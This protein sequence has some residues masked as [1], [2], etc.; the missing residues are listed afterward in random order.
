MQSLDVPYLPIQIITDIFKISKQ[1]HWAEKPWQFIPRHWGKSAIFK[2]TVEKEH[3]THTNERKQMLKSAKEAKQYS[4]LLADDFWSKLV[5]LQE[6]LL[7]LYPSF[8]PKCICGLPYLLVIPLNS[9]KNLV[10]C[11]DWHARVDFRTLSVLWLEESKFGCYWPS[12][13][14]HQC[15]HQIF[16]C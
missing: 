4:E 7:Y 15:K 9:H 5:I 1:R 10:M 13:K 6:R 8:L 14:L 2:G 12:L 3:N 11:T 16:Y